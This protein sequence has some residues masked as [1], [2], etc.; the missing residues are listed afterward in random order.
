MCGAAACAHASL[1]AIENDKSGEFAQD[2]LTP[3]ALIS[4]RARKL[5]TPEA[6]LV[7]HGFNAHEGDVDTSELVEEVCIEIKP[8]D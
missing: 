3:S 8:S 4:I 5:S 1:A 7:Q 6:L 2:R